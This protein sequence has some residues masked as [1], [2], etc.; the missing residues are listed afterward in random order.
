MVLAA[1]LSH[2][3]LAMAAAPALTGLISVNQHANADQLRMC[4]SPSDW[5]CSLCALA[6][7]RLHILSMAQTALKAIYEAPS[8]RHGDARI[9]MESQ[10]T[11]LSRFS[12]AASP[13]LAR[14]VDAAIAA[15]R[16]AAT[17]PAAAAAGRG[18][19]PLSETAVLMDARASLMV[20]LIAASL[21]R[22][23]G[24]AQLDSAGA[25]VAT[26]MLR[27]L[28]AG[29]RSCLH[30][31]ASVGAEATIGQLLS[32][33]RGLGGW[34]GA[35]VASW[36]SLVDAR[37]H[38]AADLASH[39]GFDRVANRLTSLARGRVVGVVAQQLVQQR[40]DASPPCEAAVEVAAHSSRSGSV[41]DWLA[42]RV[43]PTLIQNATAPDSAL[44][45]ALSS[46]AVAGW[47]HQ[48]ERLWNS[49]AR[50]TTQEP[51]S[52]D[53]VFGSVLVRQGEIPYETVFGAASRPKIRLSDFAKQQWPGLM[54]T[55]VPLFPADAPAKPLY[56][57]DHPPRGSPVALRLQRLG[58]I[59]NLSAGHAQAPRPQLYL[60]LPGTGAPLHSHKTAVNVLA[61]GRKLWLLLPPAAASYS[62]LHPSRLFA[63]I[64]RYRRRAGNLPLWAEEVIRRTVDVDAAH[65][66]W[67]VGVRPEAS[68]LCL[69]QAGDILVVPSG[70]AHAVLNVADASGGSVVSGVAYEM[71]LQ[72]E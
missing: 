71:Q 34:D 53:A 66:S 13:A 17:R 14:R 54:G 59:G 63:A 5:G 43:R 39:G 51:E 36:A 56:V 8:V 2:F 11:L 15:I 57:F 62:T 72:W 60:G 35:A 7:T 68:V 30:V 65:D 23:Q 41:I 12:R 52:D 6:D 4:S 18:S 27:S 10:L 55:D 9:T 19:I 45:R 29:N 49:S 48:N 64:S 25:A 61:S 42:H 50:I 67:L 16:G 58:G 38:T 47:A 31:A 21:V 44:R 33:A 32:L 20:K 46:A 26:T 70:W 28:G 3:Q 37:G 22:H 40:R 1:R 24:D 69:Q